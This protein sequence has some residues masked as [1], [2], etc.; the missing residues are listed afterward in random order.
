MIRG[1][2]NDSVVYVSKKKHPSYNEP[3][4]FR[5]DWEECYLCGGEKLVWH[6]TGLCVECDNRDDLRGTWF[7]HFAETEGA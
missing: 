2:A 3:A 4:Q 1:W 6:D 5:G 7:I